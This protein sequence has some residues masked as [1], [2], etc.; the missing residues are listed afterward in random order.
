MADE[1]F[2][3]TSWL[4]KSTY[5]YSRKVCQNKVYK[6]VQMLPIKVHQNPSAN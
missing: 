3:R 1:I 2:A 4:A 5:K 6:T